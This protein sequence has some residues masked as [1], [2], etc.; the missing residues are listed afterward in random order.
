MSCNLEENDIEL[1]YVL[2]ESDVLDSSIKQRHHGYHC[3]W[4]EAYLGS[5]TKTCWLIYRAIGL[6]N[7]IGYKY[8]FNFHSRRSHALLK[9][10]TPR[11]GSMSILDEISTSQFSFFATV[12]VLGVYVSSQFSYFGQGFVRSIVDGSLVS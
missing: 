8:I 11:N 3:T 1:P 9:F 6:L 2:I 10:W 5:S 12:Y 4:L 7:G